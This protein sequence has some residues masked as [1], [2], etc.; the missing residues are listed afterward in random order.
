VVNLYTFT[1]GSM[2][3]QAAGFALKNVKTSDGLSFPTFGFYLIRAVGTSIIYF[4]FL[5]SDPNIQGIPGLAQGFQWT[6]DTSQQT[7]S[8]ASLNGL[9]APASTQEILYTL[10]A[11]LASICTQGSV[12]S[13]QGTSLPVWSISDAIGVATPVTNL[14]FQPTPILWSQFIG[15]RQTSVAF[16]TGGGGTISLPAADSNAGALAANA[17]WGLGPASYDLNQNG[18]PFSFPIDFTT[19]IGN[20]VAGSPTFQKVTFDSAFATC[21]NNASICS[22]VGHLYQW[23]NGNWVEQWRTPPISALFEANTIVGDFDG[24]GRLEVAAQPWY[25]VQVYDLL[26]GQV[27]ASAQFTPA[28]AESGRGYG[29]FGAYDLNGGGVEELVS[30]GDFQNLIAVM[31]WQNGQ[32][33]KLWDHLIE[34]SVEARQTVH[35]PGAYPVQDVDGD[36]KL[37]ITTSIYNETGDG[38][39][40]VVTRDGM[41]GTVLLDQPQRFLIGMADVNG[42]GSVEMFTMATNGLFTPAYGQVDV[43]SFRGRT[44]QT[45]L[46]LNGAGFATQQVQSLPLNIN[47]ADQLTTIVAGPIAPGGL[48]VFFTQQA[49]TSGTIAITAWQWTNGAIAQIGTMA[50]PNLQVAASRPAAAG[51]PSILV[52]AATPGN[53]A[54]SLTATSLSGTVVQSSLIPAPLS[55]AVVGHLRPLDPPTIIVQDAL[56]NLV[57]FRPSSVTGGATVS[58]THVGRGG[59]MGGGGSITGQPGFAG[60]LLASLAG[61]GTLQTVAA[62]S[63]PVGQ[64]R[65][66]AIQPDGT[67]FW[68]SDLDR[69]PGATPAWNQAGATLV[70]AGRFRDPS[71][72]DVVAATRRGAD[73]SEEL[74]LLDGHTGQ[75]VWNDPYG[76]TPGSLPYQ[77][78]AGE[79][80]DAIYD[81]D[82]DGLDE[83]VNEASDVFWVKN[84]KDQNLINR[85]FDLGWTGVPPIFPNVSTTPFHG[86]P[87]AAD[88]LNNGTE[89]ILYGASSYLLGLMD[90]NANA[91]WNGASASGTPAVLQGI[92]DFDGN[93]TLSVVSAGAT[94]AG[95]QSVLNVH[96]G[97]TGQMLW[98]IPLSACGTFVGDGAPVGNAPTPVTVGDI[99]ADGRDEAIFACGSII[100]VVGADPGNRSGKILWSLD[101]GTPLGTPI[102]A[103]AE[104]NGQLEIVVVGSNG[105]VYGIGSP[106]PGPMPTAAGPAGG[107]GISQSFT[108][109]F[110]DPGGYQN[111]QVVDVLINNAL[112]GRRACYIA[113]TPSSNSLLLVDDA[114]DAGG[115]YQG[116]V[117]PGSGSI[118]NGQCTINGAGSSAT[119]SGTTLT[120]T[121]AITFS[122]GFAGN[123]IV[124]LS[125]QDKSAANS[126][127]QALDTWSVPGS[128]PAGP[129]VSGM[130]PARTYNFGPATYTFTFTDT[131]G[132]QDISVANVLV[133]S[134]IDGRHACY[135]AFVP[136]SESVFLVDDAGDAAGPYSGM[137]IPGSG[138][139]S[140]SQCSIGAAGSSVAGSGNTLTLTLA[141]T[142]SPGF[143]A[144]Q[145]FYLAARSTTLNSVWQAVGSVS[146]P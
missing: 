97:S 46:E 29:W 138:T 111:L 86:V 31:G 55:S 23:Q 117:L 10:A 36:G 98:S 51:T 22:D 17:T 57:A 129:A 100:Y 9:A 81:W 65:I 146:V 113:F 58:W 94:G 110:S 80:W 63:G 27:K 123:K 45:L 75:L 136:G 115:P 62:T 26:T 91:I 78:G 92:A 14:I 34:A 128:A 140:N 32:L 116:L 143:A 5:S 101:L 44:L 120:L 15:A 49:T 37:E 61:D 56:E 25:N 53:N 12:V 39:W 137:V 48:P 141:I 47:S 3:N 83:I 72:E 8:P 96:R 109:T 11:N 60:A 121:L 139:V 50:G 68:T 4:Q 103:D 19:K 132:W 89:T 102:L 107:N 145:V 127:W 114:G 67:D 21:G 70:F 124:Y 33:V 38:Q 95:G 52:T 2:V 134:A 43:V 90:A 108:V 87:V 35:V 73:G 130:S 6:V 30:L 54:A 82:H 1:N 74:N 93:G 142:F 104:G 24:N 99:N 84:G 42:D 125:A 18:N 71:H 66:V 131:N 16:Q 126:G 69:F 133:N 64:A 13:Q 41:T 76:N 77:R 59:N 118:A 135:L 88:F 20:F 119:G 85:T 106:L 112:D 7:V 40:H 28:G 144:N 105:Y 122:A 79:G